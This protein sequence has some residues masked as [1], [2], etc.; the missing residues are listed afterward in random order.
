MLRKEL[1]AHGTE[2]K[3]NS[4]C[5]IFSRII[6]GLSLPARFSQNFSQCIGTQEDH[7]SVR[8]ERC[9]FSSS[10]RWYGRDPQRCEKDR[11]THHSCAGG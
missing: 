11:M 5:N 9:T 10:L 3:G 8:L 1:F 6:R 7:G 2:E 4:T